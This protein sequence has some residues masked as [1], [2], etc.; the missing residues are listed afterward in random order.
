[1]Y[2]T[3]LKRKQLIMLFSFLFPCSVFFAQ[4]A[5][6]PSFY[7]DLPAPQLAEQIISAMTDEELLAQTFMFGWAGQKPT[8]ILTGWVKNKGLGSIKIFGWNTHDSIELAQSIYHLQETAKKCRF[9]IPLFVATDQEG[10]WI[11]HVKGLTSETPGN[12]AL[13]ASGI[14]QD[15][16]YAGFYIGREI[17]TLGIHINF[18]PAVDLLTNKNSSIIGPRAFGDDP[19][20]AGILGAAF[21]R[22]SRDAGVLTTAKHFPGHGD[23]SIDSHGRLP[24][25]LISEE[26]FFNRELLPFQMLIDSGV[27]A[28]MSGHL[29]FP[30]ALKSNIPATFSRYLLSDI[31]QKKMGFT[32]LI[33]TD[34]MMM[35]GAIRYAGNIE[36]AVQ[37]ALEAG[38]D[39]IESSTTPR[40]QDAFWKHNLQYM[41]KNPAFK[42]RVKNAAYKIL[43]AKLNYFKSGKSAPIFPD[44]ASIPQKLPDPESEQYFLSIAA[45]AVTIVRNKNIPLP[46]KSLQN[47]LLAGRYQD[48]LKV[49]KKRIPLAETSNLSDSLSY[50]VRNADT[51]IFCLADSYS[52]QKLI[53]LLRFF[54]HKNYVIISVLSPVPLLELPAIQSAVAV[55]SYSRYSFAAAFAALLGDFIP[56]G[57]KPIKQ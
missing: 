24:E 16:Y 19:K 53:E 14:P 45:H 11:R 9:S 31:L 55:Y 48:F 25:I 37:L 38:N 40:E 27:P 26:V 20:S 8:D 46:Q 13:G 41:G 34:D 2:V 35:H 43:L 49:G 5:S 32:G 36:K 54:P 29:S 56:K 57:K 30:N 50:K 44:I 7:D 17:A 15:A 21:M 23:T 33:I 42:E 10:G 39:I 18:A 28:I 47:V 3:W 6:L 51:V 1:M 52:Q 22:G 4:Q 12:L